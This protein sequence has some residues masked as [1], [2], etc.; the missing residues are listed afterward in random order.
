MREALAL[1]L[2]GLESPARELARDQLGG[3][4]V[5]GPARA[6]V[7]LLGRYPLRE[8]RR[9]VAVE[10]DVRGQSLR[11]WRGLRLE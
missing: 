8:L 11:Q 10:E 4:G 9:L 2:V 7:G 1:D 3:R 5:S 6:A